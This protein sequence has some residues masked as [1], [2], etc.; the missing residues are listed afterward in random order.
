MF[1]FRNKIKVKLE[2]QKQRDFFNR[3][4][5]KQVHSFLNV[6]PRFTSIE[7][8]RDEKSLLDFQH[9]KRH[10]STDIGSKYFRV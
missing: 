5:L 7:V 8:G 6:E 10:K 9:Y 1:A 4:R 2:L 3:Q